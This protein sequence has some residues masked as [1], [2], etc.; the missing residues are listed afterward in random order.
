[1]SWLNEPIALA[2]VHFFALSSDCYYLS[3]VEIEKKNGELGKKYVLPSTSELCGEASFAD[4]SIAWNQE[5]IAFQIKVDQPV[6]HA[7]YPDVGNGDSV[8]LFLDTRDIKTSGYNTRFC[9]HFYFL[10][11]E[12]NGYQAGETTHFR[13]DDAHPLCDAA[14]LQ[15]RV[16]RT[17]KGYSMFIIIPSSCL[18]GYDPDQ[19]D[20]LGFTYRINRAHFFPQHF[21]ASGVD[22]QIDQQPSLWASLN[23]RR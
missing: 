16:K 14:L 5:G 12:V 13:G 10:P 20:R 19:F 22:Y 23:L 3:P 1:M 2:P 4:V 9:H 7:A 11:E 21:A 18:H 17:V 15:I 6:T 8:E